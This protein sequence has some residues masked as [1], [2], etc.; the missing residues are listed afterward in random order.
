MQVRALF[1]RIIWRDD[2]ANNF[3]N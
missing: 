1:G 3:L 2:I